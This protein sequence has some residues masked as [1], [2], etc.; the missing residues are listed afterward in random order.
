MK[1]GC[2]TV[3][4]REFELERALDAMRT[5]G[6][7][8]FETQAVGPWCNH[9]Q[10]GKTDPIQLADMARKYGFQGITGL[11]M[12]D[13]NIIMNEHSVDSAVR[14]LEFADAA[15]IPVVHTGDGYKPAEM[16]DE[17]AFELLKRRLSEI[18]SRTN[19]QAMLAI[20]PHGTFSLTAEGLSRILSL[21]PAEKL[22]VNFDG[23]NIRRAGYVESNA[24]GSRWKAIEGSEKE[25]DVL[26]Q[27][28]GRVVHCHA[29]DLIRGKDGYECT[30]LGEG[31]VALQDCLGILRDVGYNGVVS[32]ETE[33]G[34]PF[35]TSFELAEKSFQYLKANVH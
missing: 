29:K 9:V 5:I 17:E 18:F 30:A 3:V 22:G 10:L 27:V 31:E 20:E 26:R 33:G 24:E 2:G 25:V 35:E 7:E 6:Y 1:I 4:F 32:L 23:A 21:A 15:G 11:W 8:Y 19:T 13:G 16:A 28:A 34:M 14:A 12:P